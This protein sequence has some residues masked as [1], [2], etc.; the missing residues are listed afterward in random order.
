MHQPGEDF[1]YAIQ[2]DILGYLVEL[3]S[4]QTLDVFFQKRIFEPLGMV[5]TVF[6]V[7]GELTAPSAVID[8]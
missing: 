5:D 6:R 1:V 3:V 4:G 7:P 2:F 8:L